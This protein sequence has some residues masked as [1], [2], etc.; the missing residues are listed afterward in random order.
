MEH[1]GTTSTQ[2]NAEGVSD[3]VFNQLY[4]GGAYGGDVI[5]PEEL[6][7]AQPK[8]SPHYR[9][10]MGQLW[11]DDSSCCFFKCITA[12]INTHVVIAGVNIVPEHFRDLYTDNPIQLLRQLGEC[13][14]HNMPSD[15]QIQNM[16]EL[17]GVSVIRHE[18][19]HNVKQFHPTGKHCVVTGVNIQVE[20]AYGHYKLMLHVDTWF[21]M[22]S[23]PDVISMLK[24]SCPREDNFPVFEFPDNLSELGKIQV[25]S[26]EK[27]TTPPP[28]VKPS[29][30]P[31]VMY[32]DG[33]PIHQPTR[34]VNAPRARPLPPYMTGTR[35]ALPSR[36]PARR[37]R[38]YDPDLDSDSSSDS[39]SDNY[40][41][42][43]GM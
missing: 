9:L 21:D 42:R 36:L 19:D 37:I 33:H 20:L 22:Q 1:S 24:V 15:T 18:H 39:S 35:G 12:Y 7:G 6:A 26:V 17:L 32:R 27:P 10:D 14:V 31:Q 40:P 2:A 38:Y 30:A 4:L 29:V 25:K 43:W 11:T 28:V 8:P 13:P 41:D 16:V 34:D 3:D 5:L 23:N